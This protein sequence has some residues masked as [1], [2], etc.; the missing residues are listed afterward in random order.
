MSRLSYV[1][2]I[3]GIAALGGL[4]FGYDTAVISGATEAIQAR[5]GLSD[6]SLGWAVSSALLGCIVGTLI[7]GWFADKFGRKR[8]LIFSGLLFSASAFACVIAPNIEL[9]V[10]ARFIGGIG[11]GVASMVTPIYIAEVA[12]AKI[13]GGL[14]TMNQIAIVSGMVLSYLANWMIVSWGDAEWMK[15]TGWRW[16]LGFEL[17]PAFIF[18]VLTIWI[19]E[20]P[21]WLA[22]RDRHSESR[23]ILKR[24]LDEDEVD[25]EYDSILSN[26]NVEEGRMHE[27]FKPG[28]RKITY[29]AMILALFQAITGINIVMYYAPRIFLDAGIGTGNAYGHSIIIGLVMVFFTI[30][31]MLLVDRVG[32]RPLMILA[33]AGMGISLFLMGFA[34]SKEDQNGTLLLVYTLSYVASFSFGMGGIYWVVVSEIFPNRIRGRAMTLSVVFLWG[35]NFLVAQFFPYMLSALQSDAFNVFA[36]SCFVCL[37][38]IVKFVPETKKRTLESIESE[39]FL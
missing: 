3:C 37:A 28:G 16:M 35:G 8:G 25:A 33:S 10:L 22:K 34:F 27:L 17:I 26:L 15:M 18:L 21:R 32:R 14:V 1:I 31:S 5:F 13:R 19:P 36:V 23:L 24:I 11:V 7:A 12:P 39:Y 2:Y 29:M 4:L 38:F 20:S 9:L 6:L 30:I